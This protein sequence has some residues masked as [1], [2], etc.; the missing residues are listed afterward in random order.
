[1]LQLDSAN[2]YEFQLDSVEDKGWTKPGANI[3]DYFNYG[4]NEETW[5]LFVELHFC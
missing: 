5:R 3:K 2:M 1:M 4:F